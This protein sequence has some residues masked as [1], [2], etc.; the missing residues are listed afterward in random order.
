MPFKDTNNVEEK[1]NQIRIGSAS[2]DKS[3]GCIVRGNRFHD[4]EPKVSELLVLLCSTDGVLSR[5]A[6]LNQLWKNQGS[7][8][9]LTQAISKLRRALGDTTRPYKIIKT[10]PK[11]GY[12]LLTNPEIVN[13]KPK[14]QDNT[15]GHKYLR[16]KFYEWNSIRNVYIASLIT[17]LALVSAGTKYLTTQ[18][19]KDIE[20]ELECSDG[21]SVQE[22]I[23]LIKALEQKIQ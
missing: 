4:L 12:R 10:V 22:C 5:K 21:L 23:S 16:R 2:F 13:V 19:P 17:I 15:Q 11:H 1:P 8:E 3:S 6:I 18:K 14:S 9:A 20:I 7:D